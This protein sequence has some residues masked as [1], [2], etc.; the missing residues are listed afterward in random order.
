MKKI[1]CVLFCLWLAP[2]N[3]G[4]NR[5]DHKKLIVLQPLDN[6]SDQ[7]ARLIRSGLLKMYDVDITIAQSMPLPANTYYKPTNRYS[8]DSLIGFLSDKKGTAYTIIGLTSRDVFTTKGTNKYWGI[9]GLGTLNADASIV[10]TCRLHRG[11]ALND[12]L[13]KLTAHELGH[14]FGLPHCPDKTCIMADAE[15]HNTFYRETGFCDKCRKMLADNGIMLKQAT[16][17]GRKTAVPTL[18]LMRLL[19]R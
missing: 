19:S 1:L 17:S 11:T 5:H 10:S 18:L 12:E 8:A 13:I 7:K 4:C 16:V 6:F 15:G 3:T 9:M 14:N 2:I